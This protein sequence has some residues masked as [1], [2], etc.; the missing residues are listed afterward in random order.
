MG[1]LKSQLV[2]QSDS[3]SVRNGDWQ[4]NFTVHCKFEHCEL[5][6]LSKKV[7]FVVYQD[8]S[9]SVWNICWEYKFEM[10]LPKKCT[11]ENAMKSAITDKCENNVFEEN[12]ISLKQ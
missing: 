10:V 9:T 1:I 11:S 8:Q 2:P 6:F 4:V 3:N 7:S 12:S 5:W